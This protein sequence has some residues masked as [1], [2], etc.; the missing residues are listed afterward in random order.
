MAEKVKRLFLGGPWH[1]LEAQVDADEWRY[2]VPS[3]ISFTGPARP[4]AVYRATNYVRKQ[5]GHDSTTRSVFVPE[6]WS[7][8]EARE[9]LVAYLMRRWIAES[10]DVSRG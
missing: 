4:R 9:A 5:M 10:P 7:D 2:R 1:G 6:R 3:P 8:R